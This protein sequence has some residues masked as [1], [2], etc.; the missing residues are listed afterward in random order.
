MGKNL[1]KWLLYSALF[2]LY[3]LHNDLWLWNDASLMFGIPIGLLY[4]IAFC[5]AASFL[6]I[7]IVK[8]IWPTHLEVETKE[9]MQQ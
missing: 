3:L 2:A 7:L 9:E 4:H 6:F 5:I 8:N 1:P